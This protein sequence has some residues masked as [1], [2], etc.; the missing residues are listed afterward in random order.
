MSSDTNV[1]PQGCPI[2]L[3]IRDPGS[4][5]PFMLSPKLEDSSF[6]TARER[7][8]GGCLLIFKRLKPKRCI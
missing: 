1:S 5:Q 6:T 3:V 8:G 4:P 7:N 2:Y